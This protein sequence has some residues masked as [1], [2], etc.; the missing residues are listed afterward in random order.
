VLLPFLVAYKCG[1]SLFYL[2]SYYTPYRLKLVIVGP[3]GRRGFFFSSLFLGL[4]PVLGAFI[5]VIFG[6]EGPALRVGLEALVFLT[7]AALGASFLDAERLA[8]AVIPAT[9]APVFNASALVKVFLD[10]GAAAGLLGR[11]LLGGVCC[12]IF[13]VG[14]FVLVPELLVLFNFL[15]LPLCRVD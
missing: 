1:Y 11:P 2:Y 7:G 14:L 4:G 9:V 12:V 10:L 5:E 6:P 8:I 15:T 3:E 13:L